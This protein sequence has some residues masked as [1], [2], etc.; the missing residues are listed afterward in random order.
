MSALGQ[1][2]TCRTPITTSASPPKSGHCSAALEW[3]L[4]A[5][6]GHSEIDLHKQKDRL[7]AVSPKSDLVFDQAA[8]AA[9]FFFL[10]QP[11]NK[12]KT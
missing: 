3:L 7:T 10:R 12:I 2:R 6:S 8:S 11:E 1:K 9:A 4:S 5:R